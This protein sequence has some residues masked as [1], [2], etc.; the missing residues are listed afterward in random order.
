MPDFQSIPII[1]DK[2]ALRV[3]PFANQASSVQS[4][5]PSVPGSRI[6]SANPYAGPS[7]PAADAVA[8]G[9]I[10][11]DETTHLQEAAAS[12]DKEA[13]DLLDALG[14]PLGIAAGMAAVYG[15]YKGGQALR[16]SRM[17]AQGS[18]TLPDGTS[19]FV[20]GNDIPRTPGEYYPGDMT[21]IVPVGEPSP[22]ITPEMMRQPQQQVGM[23]QRLALP[24]PNRQITD[25]RGSRFNQA[26]P[27]ERKAIPDLNKKGR[28]VDA[29][30]NQKATQDAQAMS[31]A[32]LE[33]AFGQS[34]N[35]MKLRA[36]RTAAKAVRQVR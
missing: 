15:A 33:K 31:K 21:N 12:G 32:E 24:A 23:E 28:E 7:S 34:K 13:F 5:G 9:D 16:N 2:N 22:Y 27:V 10:T 36:A 25:Q 8:D 30:Y 11:P 35:G 18:D 6:N 4:V 17:A 3:D 14:L 19:K 29:A 20:N 1:S 26:A